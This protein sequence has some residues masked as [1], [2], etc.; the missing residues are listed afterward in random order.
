VRL[1]TANSR[2]FFLNPGLDL[3]QFGM[4]SMAC[5]ARDGFS[6]MADWVAACPSADDRF[7]VLHPQQYS[8]DCLGM[9]SPCLC[10]DHT[11]NMPVLFESARIP[12]KL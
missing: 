6:R 1:D 2:T 4:G 3:E 12:E 5:D 10:A 7:L 8:L 9:A 11:S